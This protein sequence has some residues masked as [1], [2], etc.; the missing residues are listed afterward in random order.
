[1]WNVLMPGIIKST[2]DAMWNVLMPHYFL[3]QTTAIEEKHVREE[4][5]TFHFMGELTGNI[6]SC[7]L[8]HIPDP[9]S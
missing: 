8:L 4:S 2:C 3:R 7:K 5:G 9:L 6:Y 1:M